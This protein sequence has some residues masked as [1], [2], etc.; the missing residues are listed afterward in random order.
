[1]DYSNEAGHLM[2]VDGFGAYG[3]YWDPQTPII[4]K[5]RI[6]VD[7]TAYTFKAHLFT[8]HMDWNSAPGVSTNSSR[9]LSYNHAMWGRYAMGKDSNTSYGSRSSGFPESYYWRTMQDDTWNNYNAIDPFGVP[10]NF[11]EADV[12]NIMNN[13]ALVNQ[14]RPG[15][16]YEN[17]IKVECAINAVTDTTTNGTGSAGRSNHYYTHRAIA[18]RVKDIEVDI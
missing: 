13:W 6:T 2:Y 18:K 10:S 4:S 15:L 17:S 12:V 16:R 5:I 14:M 3:Q 11:G 7:G 8:T 1:M 9:A